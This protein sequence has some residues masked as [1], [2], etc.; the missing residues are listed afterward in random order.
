MKKNMIVAG[1]LLGSVLVLSGCRVDGLGHQNQAVNS[2]D[3]GNG[4]TA[5]EGD[6]DAGDIVVNESDQPGIRVTE[7]LHWNGD[8]G[9]KPKT[10]HPVAGGTLTLRHE[11]SGSNCAVDYKVEIP[12]G[13]KI[14]LRTT[15][16]DI[17]LRALTGEVKATTTAGDIEANALGA[18]NLVATSGAGDVT[19]RFAAV[20]G[21]VEV[22][23]TAGDATVRLPSASYNVTT[24]T[25]AGEKTVKVT[26]DPSSPNSVSVRTGAGD[27]KVLPS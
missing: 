1:T 13:V 26:N 3:V 22:E 6:T 16:G 4:V 18:K 19:V 25:V 15:A 21:H 23:T 7:T 27:A 11:C 2:Y 9:D 17:T 14:T 5:L 24:R 10:E 12:K 8:K 20:P